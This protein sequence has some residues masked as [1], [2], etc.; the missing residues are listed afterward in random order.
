[1]RWRR[2]TAAARTGYAYFDFRVPHEGADYHYEVNVTNVNLH[3]LALELGAPTNHLEG[4]LAG[5]WS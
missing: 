1:M 3:A 2:F 5:Q 4:T